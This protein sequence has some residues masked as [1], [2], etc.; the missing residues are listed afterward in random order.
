MLGVFT[1]PGA[2]ADAANDEAGGR[3]G[4]QDGGNRADNRGTGRRYELARGARRTRGRRDL[5]RPH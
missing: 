2:D 5:P 1:G 4:A 3:G